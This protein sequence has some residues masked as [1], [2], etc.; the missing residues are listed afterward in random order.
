MWHQWLSLITSLLIYEVIQK[1]ILKIS[2]TY[3]IICL[4]TSMTPEYLCWSCTSWTELHFYKRQHF[5]KS[6][7]KQLR[8][9]LFLNNACNSMPKACNFIKKETLTQVFSCKISKITRMTLLST[10]TS[11][12]YRGVYKTPA[13][14]WNE[15]FFSNSKRLKPAK[16]CCKALQSLCYISSGGIRNKTL[17]CNESYTVLNIFKLN[18]TV[19]K[20]HSL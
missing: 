5:T 16:Y 11:T 2:C 18:F 15:E 20:Q 19:D 17:V 8:Q 3:L 10:S 14:I 6:T 12:N 4:N 7:G 9:S 13:Y 1:M